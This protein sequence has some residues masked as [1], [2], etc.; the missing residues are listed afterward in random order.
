MSGMK[1]F[2]AII[3]EFNKV[4]VDTGITSA[5]C[6]ISDTL[7]KRDIFD[8]DIEPSIFFPMDDDAALNVFETQHLENTLKSDLEKNPGTILFTQGV[9]N[10][11]SNINEHVVASETKF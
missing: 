10:E 1:A 3:K 8:K 4:E 2:K 5:E 6:S 7:K 9:T 11:A